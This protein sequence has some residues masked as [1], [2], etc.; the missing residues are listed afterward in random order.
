MDVFIHYFHSSLMENSLSQLIIFW[1][2]VIFPKQNNKLILNYYGVLFCLYLFILFIY[3]LVF[4]C[5][6]FICIFVLYFALIF[7]YVLL[8][9]FFVCFCFLLMHFKV[10]LFI[11]FFVFDIT[12]VFVAGSLSV[13]TATLKQSCSCAVNCAI[14]KWNLQTSDWRL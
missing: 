11:F 13:R 8:L 10:V 12:Y 1:W 2:F 6:V 5:F 3:C 14:K 9:L 7:V 4:I